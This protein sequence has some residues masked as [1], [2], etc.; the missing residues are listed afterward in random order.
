MKKKQPLY[1]SR[2]PDPDFP[3]TTILLEWTSG[4]KKSESGLD[5]GTRLVLGFFLDVGF[6]I[7]KLKIGTATMLSNYPSRFT[8]MV[9]SEQSTGYCYTLLA[10]ILNPIHCVILIEEKRKMKRN[11]KW[12]IWGFAAAGANTCLDKKGNGGGKWRGK[13][14]T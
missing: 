12:C 11:K 8:L 4:S 3:G 9:I 6:I 5:E 14:V 7:P 13:K 2:K 10:P 1:F